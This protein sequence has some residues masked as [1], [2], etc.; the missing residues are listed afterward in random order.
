MEET[1]SASRLVKVMNE[2]GLTIDI[3]VEGSETEGILAD[4]LYGSNSFTRT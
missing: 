3:A 2:T 1:E 4:I